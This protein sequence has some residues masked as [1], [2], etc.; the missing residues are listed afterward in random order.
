MLNKWLCYIAEY[1][2][3]PNF[4]PEHQIQN[5]KEITEMRKIYLVKKNPELPA[6]GNNWLVINTIEFM[7][8]I[9]TQERQKRRDRFGQ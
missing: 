4:E 1:P 7:N 2:W 9:Q 6:D 3:S 8:N 5:S